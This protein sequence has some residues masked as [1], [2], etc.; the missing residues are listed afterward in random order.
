MTQ[1]KEPKLFTDFSPKEIEPQVI[2]KVDF[3]PEPYEYKELN[4]LNADDPN[5]PIDLVAELEALGLIVYKEDKNSLEVTKSIGDTNKLAKYIAKKGLLLSNN[6]VP[7]A[8]YDDTYKI[9]ELDQNAIQKFIRKTIVSPLI[10]DITISLRQE[11]ELGE[12]LL[13]EVIQNSPTENPFADNRKYLI[14]FTKTYNIKTN[15]FQ[16]AQGDDFFTGRLK[17]TPIEYDT[18]ETQDF[19]HWLEFLLGDSKRT[20]LEFLGLSF[21]NS[22]SLSQSALVSVGNTIEGI[23][24]HGNGK[25]ELQLVVKRAFES[26]GKELSSEIALSDMTGRDAETH[27]KPLIGALVNF[28]DD[29]DTGFIQRSQQLKKLITGQAKVTGRDLYEA[30]VYFQNKAN[31]W[32]NTNELPK[33]SS[34]DG[35]TERRIDLLVFQKNMRLKE[36]QEKSIEI[37]DYQTRLLGED[38]TDLRKLMYLAIQTARS[39]WFDETTQTYNKETLYQSDYAKKIKGDWQVSNNSAKQFI[40]E[41]DYIITNKET[42]CVSRTELYADYKEWAQENGNKAMASK[43]FR[44]SIVKEL[45]LQKVFGKNNDGDI[46]L[47]VDGVKDRRFYGIKLVEDEIFDEFDDGEEVF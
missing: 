44:K 31:F 1:E 6:H 28:D 30:P 12:Q 5:Y 23:T 45:E 11:N 25:S 37:Y 24:D 21:I 17:H 9:W 7:L 32:L 27:L 3:T 35:A 10:G 47:T 41:S 4:F 26:V 8:S 20:F 18:S 38:T 34:N 16:E 40:E 13:R 2:E 39:K 43:A 22:A 42:D 29:A 36:N 15:E 14:P 46:R 33:L 19:E